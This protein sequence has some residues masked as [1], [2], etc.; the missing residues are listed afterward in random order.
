M[1]VELFN[2]YRKYLCVC[3]DIDLSLDISRMKFDDNFFASMSAQFSRA[4]DEMAKLEAGGIANPDENR[5]VGHYWLRN[6]SIAPDAEIR[7][8]IEEVRENVKNFAKRVHTGDLRAPNGEKYTDLLVI[9][10][11]GSALGPQWIASA[12]S[13][14]NDAMRVHFLKRSR[15]SNISKPSSSSSF[16][17]LA[18]HPKRAMACSPPTPSCDRVAST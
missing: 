10:I 14:P 7:R 3:E 17:N 2:R 18:R 11:G 15:Q 8:E 1:S 4:F 13:T 5:R 12:L 9:G 6:P 16:R